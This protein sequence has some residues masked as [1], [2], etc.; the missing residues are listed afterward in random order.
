[1]GADAILL[2]DPVVEMP[3]MP[4]TQTA[5]TKVIVYGDMREGYQIVDR[6]GLTVIR[7]EIT[8]KGAVK[9]WFRKRTGGDVLQPEALKVLKIKA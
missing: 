9:F 4:D 8:T 2:G 3:D 1:M 7:D 6:L 5:G